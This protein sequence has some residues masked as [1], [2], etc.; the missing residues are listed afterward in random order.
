MKTMINLAVNQ[1][2]SSLWRGAGVNSVVI[3]INNSSQVV[4]HAFT[5]RE[6]FEYKMWLHDTVAVVDGEGKRNVKI[7]SRLWNARKKN[8]LEFLEF[9]RRNA[10][11]E[12]LTYTSFLYLLGSRGHSRS[13]YLVLN[14]HHLKSPPT[15]LAHHRCRANLNSKNVQFDFRYS[16]PFSLNHRRDCCCFLCHKNAKWYWLIMLILDVTGLK[17]IQLP[18]KWIQPQWNSER[19]WTSS[20]PQHAI[21]GS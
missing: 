6:K 14:Q 3:F 11:C 8:S 15:K 10:L 7:V 9:L 4:E 1:A 20:N 13:E 5:F 19:F 17:Y 18:F 2:R 12:T 16:I 21:N